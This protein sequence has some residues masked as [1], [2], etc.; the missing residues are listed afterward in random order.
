M[1]YYILSVK[2]FLTHATSSGELIKQPDNKLRL[3]KFEEYH[4][5][6]F[7]VILKYL[8]NIQSPS[9]HVVAHSK[10]E[11]KIRIVDMI[12]TVLSAVMSSDVV[13]YQINVYSHYFYYLHCW[14]KTIT[15]GAPS[16]LKNTKP[17]ITLT[18]D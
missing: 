13:Y 10:L 5:F 18:S 11:K 8:K 14:D 9:K 16:L 1:L 6:N 15:T 4:I 2:T 17:F 3:L 7:G 12:L